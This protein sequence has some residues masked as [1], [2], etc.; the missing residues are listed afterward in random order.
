VVPLFK[1][2]HG[3]GGSKVARALFR[4]HISDVCIGFWAYRSDA[5]R[6]LELAAGGFEIEADMFVECVGNS[7]AE[8]PITYRARVDQPKLSSLRDGVRKGLFSCKRRFRQTQRNGGRQ[9]EKK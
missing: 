3:S 6:R 2:V 9:A 8:I 1:K 5:I 7:V 4:A